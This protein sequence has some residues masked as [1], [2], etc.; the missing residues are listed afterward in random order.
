MKQI[1]ISTIGITLQA[2]LIDTPTAEEIWKNLPI[3]GTV[4]VWGEEIYFT[5]PLKIAL[6]ADATQD[7][8]VGALAYWPN[9]PALCIFFGPTPAST[10]TKPR[11]YSPVNIIGHITDD[12]MPLKSISDGTDI[13]IEALREQP[14]K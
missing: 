9:G 10:G 14:G 4:N 7:L 11:A 2:Y 8:E 13:L 6:E 5:I 12:T 1:T 3:K